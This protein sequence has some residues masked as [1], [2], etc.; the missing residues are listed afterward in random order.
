MGT[1]ENKALVRRLIEDSMNRRDPAACAT[2][3]APDATNFGRPIGREGFQQVLAEIFA[4]FP[5]WHSTIEDLVAEGDV[6]VAHTLTVATHAGTPARINVHNMLG[7]PP[8]GKSVV[9]RSIHVVQLR[10]GLIVR[11]DAIRDDLETMQQI[12]R[13]PLPG[14]PG[15]AG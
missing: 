3:F 5:D 9:M 15:A 10:D 11:H 12:G 4:T 14:V 2:F 6:V 1:N 13:W 8:T 7:I